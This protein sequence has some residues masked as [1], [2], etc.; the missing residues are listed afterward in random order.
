[1]KNLRHGAVRWGWAQGIN[2]M[3]SRMRTCNL[4]DDAGKIKQRRMLLRG[5]TPTSASLHTVNSSVSARGSSSLHC[6]QSGFNPGLASTLLFM[7]LQ[8]A[9]KILVLVEII[10][11]R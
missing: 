5:H 3:R 9:K 2:A 6:L 8:K 1:M 10:L 7:L 4:H 11:A